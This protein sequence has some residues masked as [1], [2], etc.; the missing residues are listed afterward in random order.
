MLPGAAARRRGETAQIRLDFNWAD[1]R[2]AGKALVEHLSHE[3][4]MLEEAERR[5]L[6]EERARKAAEEAERVRKEEELAKL[7]RV[8]IEFDE[9]IAAN[10]GVSEEFRNELKSNFAKMEE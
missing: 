9:Y 4:W 3:D 7:G 6:E 5:R 1:L 2:P 8:D 10:I